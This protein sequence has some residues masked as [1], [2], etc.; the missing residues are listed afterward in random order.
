MA[1]D[2]TTAW[3]LEEIMFDGE[4]YAPGENIRLFDRSVNAG[5]LHQRMVTLDR[6]EA[7]E[8]ADRFASRRAVDEDRRSAEAAAA[9]EAQKNALRPIVGELVAEALAAQS[10]KPA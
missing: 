6:D 4:R 10:K 8:A 9:A 1:R 3:A 5:L 7:E 2:K